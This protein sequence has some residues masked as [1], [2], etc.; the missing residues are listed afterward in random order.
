MTVQYLIP[1]RRKQRVWYAPLKDGPSPTLPGPF[2]AC[3][4][5][6]LED[7]SHLKSDFGPFNLERGYLMLEMGHLIL[8]VG[9]LRPAQYPLRSKT[10]E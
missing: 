8:H 10:T 9:P 4:G 7:I 5:F 3:H 2:Q 6:A 1:L